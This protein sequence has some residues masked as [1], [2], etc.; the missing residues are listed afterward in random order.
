MLAIWS[1]ELKAY[2]S[3]VIGYMY[4]G[5]FILISGLVFSLTNL[6]TG[7]TNYNQALDGL[8][9]IFLLSIPML[10]MKIISEETKSKTDQLLFTCPLSINQIVVGKYLAA[11]TLFFITTLITGLYPIIMGMYGTLAY[12]EIL[13]A[14]IG[15]CLMGAA[16]IS[17]GVFI[18]SLTENQVVAAVGTFSALLFIW[19]IDAIQQGVPTGLKAGIVFAV[20]LAALIVLI[21]YYSTKNIFVSVLAAALGV[22]SIASIYVIK[23]DLYY[24]IIVKFLGWFSLVTR[25]QMFSMGVL[26]FSSIVYYIS[27]SFIFVF[28]TIRMLE[29]RRWC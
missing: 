25:Y 2:F 6:L 26:D 29:K 4:M 12:L 14:Y 13:S 9:F 5:A 3:S 24:G 27:F 28:L 20:I 11:V 16:F 18:S 10:T 1:K 23:K 8:T 21:I 15:F 19:I 7:S 22:I 17:I